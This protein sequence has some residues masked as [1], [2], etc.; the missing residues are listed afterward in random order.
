M[1]PCGA[2]GP[3][4][5]VEAARPGPPGRRPLRP[6]T[7]PPWTR[8][9][10]RGTTSRPSCSSAR[11]TS[12]VSSR[13]STPG[14]TRSQ[15]SERGP[16]GSAGAGADAAQRRQR[17]H[18]VAVRRAAAARRRRGRPG[19]RQQG[20]VQGAGISPGLPRQKE[21]LRTASQWPLSS[22]STACVI[23]GE[24]RVRERDAEARQQASQRGP[25]SRETRRGRGA[26]RAAGSAQR[27]RGPG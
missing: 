18:G 11:G 7:P 19:R 14:G 26:G 4:A 8:T 22:T 2:G 10:A 9:S 17:A 15:Y 12:H 13:T 16:G 3:R 20:A 6:L 5:R 1:G 24:L 21:Q 23:G 27:W 25:S